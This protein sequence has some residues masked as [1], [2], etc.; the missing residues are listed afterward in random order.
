MGNGEWKGKGR[1]SYL[2]AT[3]WLLESIFSNHPVRTKALNK[4]F[5]LESFCSYRAIFYSPVFYSPVFTFD[6]LNDEIFK[7]G[8]TV[9][10]ILNSCSCL[11]PSVLSTAC[12]AV[13]T[14]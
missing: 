3:F 14:T 7:S 12:L 9:L 2:M 4:L 8:E 11:E 5:K 13:K 1:S 10:E 6:M